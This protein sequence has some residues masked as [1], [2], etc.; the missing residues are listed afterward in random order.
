MTVRKRYCSEYN[1]AM[2]PCFSWEKSELKYRCIRRLRMWAA[3]DLWFFLVCGFVRTCT[4][5]SLIGW[6]RSVGSNWFWLAN[7]LPMLLTF[8]TW[9]FHP[10]MTGRAWNSSSNFWLMVVKGSNRYQF[11]TRTTASSRLRHFLSQL[12]GFRSSL[13]WGRE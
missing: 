8:A 5:S 3:L 11:H 1:K 10:S 6:V 12:K 9:T 7:H 4:V 13:K 2:Q